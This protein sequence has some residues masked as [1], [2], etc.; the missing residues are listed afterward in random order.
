MS[1]RKI[2]DLHWMLQKPAMDLL[3]MC[4]RETYDVIITCTYRS[5][6]EQDV[7]FAQGRTT[8]GQI[9]TWAKGGESLHNFRTGNKPAALAFDVV[10]IIHGRAYWTTDGAGHKIWHTIGELGESLGLDW[11]GRWTGGKREYPHFQLNKEGLKNVENYIKETQ[12]T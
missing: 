10:P 9:V 4:K 5:P 11:A 6:V 7:L 12:R 2:E 8:K 3:V 1:S